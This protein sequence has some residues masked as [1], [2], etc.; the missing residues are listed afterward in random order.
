MVK[1]FVGQVTRRSIEG[2]AFS[3][4]DPLE[5]I[6]VSIDL[7]LGH[8]LIAKANRFRPDL[9][10]KKIHPTGFCGFRF[11]IDPEIYK[12]L[13]PFRLRVNCAT[14]TLVKSAIFYESWPE[15][16]RVSNSNG[17]QELF[18]FLHI[19]KTA[20]TSFRN[21]LYR[22]FDHDTILPNPT[23]LDETK[24]Y[25][26]FEQLMEE[27][28]PDIR[29]ITGHY[30]L[31]LTSTF[32]VKPTFLTFLRD[33]VERTISHIFHAKKYFDRFAEMTPKEILEDE[34]IR[35][36]LNNYQ[37]RFFLSTRNDEKNLDES[38]FRQAMSNLE[39]CEFVGITE[40]FPTSV[41]KAEKLFGWKF[42]NQLNVNVNTEKAPLDPQLIDQIKSFN[43]FDIRLY[44]QARSMI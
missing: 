5:T 38:D 32:E 30:P 22:V 12:T 34:V 11:D 1:G 36:Q 9:L 7:G 2:W 41:A 17:K 24:L 25:P 14:K 3:E 8:I 16:I 31:S 6:D 39:N 40:Y 27:M 15:R 21:M 10:E 20:G 37:T 23:V 4:N 33:P 43:Y 35:S 26:T 13:D 44:E 19:P 29:L 28:Q 18:F 42:D